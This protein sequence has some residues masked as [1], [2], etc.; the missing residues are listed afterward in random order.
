MFRDIQHSM[1]MVLETR[2]YILLILIVYYK[3]GQIFLQ[4]VNVILLSNAAEVYYKMCQV[5]Y[6]KMRQFHKKTRQNATILL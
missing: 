3:M 6:S 5:F 1:R 4:N 2:F